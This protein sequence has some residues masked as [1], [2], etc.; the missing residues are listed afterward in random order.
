MFEDGSQQVL[1]A[2]R[3]RLIYVR[4]AAET[5]RST[6]F[7]FSSRVRITPMAHLD[8]APSYQTRALVRAL[9]ILDAFSLDRSVLGVKDLHLHL[10]LPKPTVSRLTR[11]LES[12]GYLR[13]V[14]GG[15]ELGTKTFELGSLFTHHHGEL[16]FARRPL[17]ELAISASQTSALATLA[18]RNIVHLVVVL[19]PHPVQY[20]TEVGSR[21]PAH[22][23]GLGKALLAALTDAQL[24]NT[25]GPGPYPGFTPNTICKRDD[26]IGELNQIRTRG[27]AVDNEESH[28]G[29]KCVSVLVN[30]PALGPAAISVSGPSA[31]FTSSGIREFAR[32]LRQTAKTLEVTRTGATSVPVTA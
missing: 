20:V 31:A 2:R 6:S 15:F 7:R 4:R 14:D 11:A 3:T 8:D 18:G 9:A 10:G 32:M 29:L 28:L 24:D 16:D 22:A 23:T 26:L 1:R 13:A 5:R 25:L 12:E 19:S 17:E 30:T 21:A 27:F